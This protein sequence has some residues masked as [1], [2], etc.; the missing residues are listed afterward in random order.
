MKMTL[1]ICDIKITRRIVYFVVGE[2]GLSS[3]DD[4]TN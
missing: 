3:E 1:D 4:D 2:S